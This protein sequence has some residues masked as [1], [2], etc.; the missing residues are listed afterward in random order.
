ML[1]D[2][3][4]F[5]HWIDN[6]GNEAGGIKDIHLFADP[7]DD[8]DYYAYSLFVEL[9][10]EKDG[11][12]KKKKFV[13]HDGCWGEVIVKKSDLDYYFDEVHKRY[14]GVDELKDLME[15]DEE[16]IYVTEKKKMMVLDDKKKYRL[17][18]MES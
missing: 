16:G 1:F 12:W 18:A 3:R 2:I 6:P 13:E 17:E 14:F 5:E 11:L 9:V 7:Y 4:I 15:I 10:N 8:R